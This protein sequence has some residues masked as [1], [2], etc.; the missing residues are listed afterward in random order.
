MLHANRIQRTGLDTVPA[1]H[2]HVLKNHRRLEG[3]VQ[4]LEHFMGT[5]RHGR[6]K[7]LVRVAGFRIA[8]FIVNYGKRFF[9]LQAHI[10]PYCGAGRMAVITG[11]LEIFHQVIN[12][13]KIS[14]G[15]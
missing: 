7:A 14:D 11:V 12:Q 4:L 9:G 10:H 15:R 6:A 2:A 1:C 5:R 8:P 13:V 3:T